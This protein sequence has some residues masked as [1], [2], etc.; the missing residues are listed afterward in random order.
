MSEEQ[1]EIMIKL[2]REISDTLK[3]EQDRVAVCG[4]GSTGFCMSCY[5]AHDL[6]RP[7]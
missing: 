5:I 3:Q 2:L 7:R 6:G 4:H 1:A